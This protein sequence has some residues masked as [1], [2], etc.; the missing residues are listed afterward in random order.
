MFPTGLIIMFGIIGFFI[1]VSILITIKRRHSMR[2]ST[3]HPIKR[4]LTKEF[5]A[6]GEQ[7]A[8]EAS[9]IHTESQL[10]V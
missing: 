9:A 1:L 7:A 8:A 3:K 6:E 4:G 2:G 10:Q 5:S